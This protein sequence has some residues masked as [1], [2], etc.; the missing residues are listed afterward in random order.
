MNVLWVFDELSDN[1][2][3]DDGLSLSVNIA[4]CKKI[5]EVIITLG[6]DAILVAY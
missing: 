5:L 3:S 1:N 6:N 4:V 2:K